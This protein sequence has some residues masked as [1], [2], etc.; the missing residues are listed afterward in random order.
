MMVN[1]YFKVESA[2]EE[3]EA[4]GPPLPPGY[5]SEGGGAAAVEDRESDNDDD[6]EE[7][8]EEESEV[9]GEV[10]QY[11]NMPVQHSVMPQEFDKKFPLSHEV[12][13]EHGSKPVG[14]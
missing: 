13:L 3:D 5:S 11:S 1:L 2:D 7:D 6:E 9:S 12:V 10:V 4:V 8:M 14:G